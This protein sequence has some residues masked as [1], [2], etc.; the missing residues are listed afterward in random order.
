MDG[1]FLVG[2][3]GCAFLLFS[4]LAPRR[5]RFGVTLWSSVFQVFTV[6]VMGIYPPL[7]LLT[8]LA[9]W[10]ELVRRAEVLRWLPLRI[11]VLLL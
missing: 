9:L 4:L 5:W 2:V 3:L 7:T 11:F 8:G 1:L 6:P 10:P